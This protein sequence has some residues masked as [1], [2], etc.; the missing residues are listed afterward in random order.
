M[1]NIQ[2]LDND[3]ETIQKYI[4]LG[5]EKFNLTINVEKNIKAPIQRKH[6]S[7]SN[8]LDRQI[9]NAKNINT[10]KATKIKIAMEELNTLLDTDKKHLSIS[11]A[12]E[13]Y[14][15]TKANQI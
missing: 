6:K 2:I 12:K 7:L 13:Q 5:R 9:R 8:M 10:A 3:F 14:F 4:A 15:T 11:E 1:T